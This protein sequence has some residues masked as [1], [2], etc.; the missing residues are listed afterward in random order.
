MSAQVVK[1]VGMQTTEN[2]TGKE[3]AAILL[4]SLGVEAAAQVLKNLSREDVD[5]ITTRISVLGD[6][7]P[8]VKQS[9]L[10]EFHQMARAQQ[11][12]SM[13]GTGYVRQVLERALGGEE[14]RKIM[15][16]FQQ[17]ERPFEALKGVDPRQLIN[18]IRHEQPQTIA[19]I[20]SYLDADQAAMVLNALPSDLQSEVA[21]R[22]ATM[23]QTAPEVISQIEAVLEKQVS[24]LSQQ[25]LRVV[26][27]VK[28][29]AEVLNLVDRATEKNILESI[30]K[31]SSELAQEVKKLMFV[32]EDI[33]LVDDRSMQK[34]AKEI[35]TKELSLALKAASEEVKSKFFKSISERAAEMIKEE[36]EFMG[37]VRLKDVEEA[38][39]RIVGVVRRLEEEGE[40]II[41]GR[42]RGEGEVIV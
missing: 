15:N 40:I 17:E 22:I 24:S 35:D 36:M 21:G 14:S 19:L 9:V 23:E 39:Q 6:I 42:G 32:F 18:F 7:P 2:L 31:Q 41:T 34:V 3:K 5:E 11:D 29:V 26:G 12:V 25:N 1:R 16:R 13:G 4:V 10:E 38:Q 37:P 30:E 20:L 8:Q 28:A 27:G 33:V